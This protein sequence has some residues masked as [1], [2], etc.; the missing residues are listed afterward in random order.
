M[1]PGLASTLGRLPGY[2]APAWAELGQ[3]GALGLLHALAFA[4]PG[5][6][7]LELAALALLAWR[8]GRTSAPGPGFWLGLGFGTGWLLGGVWWLF[9]SMYRYG[10]LPA[11]LSALAVLAL[12]GFLALY[13][14]AALALFVRWRRGRPWA[15]AS[16]F[17]AL[18]LLAE[19][20]RGLIFTGF[21]W[22]ASGYAHVEGPLGALAPWIGVYGIAACAP[23]LAAFVVAAPRAGKPVWRAPLLVLAV[24]A[25]L[26]ALPVPDFTQATGTLRLSLLQ[27]NVPQDEKFAEEHLP[28]TLAWD[29]RSLVTARGDLVVGPETVI[30]LLPDQLPDGYWDALTAHFREGHRAALIGVPLGSFEKGYTNSAAGLSLDTAPLLGGFYR[31]DKHHLVPFGEFIPLGFH[32]FVDM[33]NMPL[34]DFNRGPLNPLSFEV[35]G[36]RI[37]PNICYEDLFGE[38]LATRFVD[39][40]KAPT[41][42]ANIGNIGWFGDTVAVSQHLEI[43]RMRALEFQRPMLRATNTGATAVIDHRGRVTARLEPFTQGVLE[44]S[45][46]GR[47]GITPYAWWVGRLGLWPL[48]LAALACVGWAALQPGPGRAAP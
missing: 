48:I 20:A 25:L 10:G 37:A 33:M 32:W 3:G 21:P 7:L 43:S 12:C 5:L 47:S 17:A 13:Y 30:P 45:V 19:L 9:I 2:L 41:M 40:A 1:K 27:G 11:W 34:G 16:L 29:A 8:A 42:F 46:Q 26:Y 36:E 35:K 39:A 4:R 23:W 18:W 15:D 44:A 6:W 14:A 24:L 31:Y 38:E 22:V 28:Q